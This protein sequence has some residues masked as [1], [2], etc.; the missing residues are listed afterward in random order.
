MLLSKHVGRYSNLPFHIEFTNVKSEPPHYHEELEI[1]FVLQG[2]VKYKLFHQEYEINEGE[3]LIVDTEDLHYIC[4]SS[5]DIVMIN[6]YIDITGFE[7][8]YPNIDYMIFA[9]EYIG[10]E[11]EEIRQRL[12]NKMANLKTTM[13]DLMNLTLLKPHDDTIVRQKLDKLISVLVEHFQAFRFEQ[14]R[15]K[16]LDD[17]MPSKSMETVYN[18]FRYIYD[19]Y[20]EKL[21][22]EI[23]ADAV[24][25]SPSYISH[26]V[27]ET[28][29][30]TLQELINYVRVEFAAKLMQTPSLT[31]TQVSE[32]SGFSSLPYFNKCFSEWYDMTPAQ[33]RKKHRPTV[34]ETHG[35][36]DMTRC[37]SLLE[38]YTQKPINTDIYMMREL[39]G[40][41]SEMSKDELWLMLQLARKIRQ[42]G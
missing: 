37:I 28:C 26:L 27:K 36:L 15:Y 34:T 2:T 41:L 12:E 19:N 21:S 22:L 31:L 7:T 25:F 32:N 3:L 8:V 24:G 29:G 42:T 20:S 5:E 40:I 14:H 9:C 16:V 35:K 39:T 10:D 6:M 18:I 38:N 1:V 23:I 33:Y 17:S 13:S 4:D 30:L 11:P